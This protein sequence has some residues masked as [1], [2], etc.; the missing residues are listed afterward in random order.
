MAQS[1]RIA[2]ATRPS[3]VFTAELQTIVHCL[4]ALLSSSTPSH[5]HLIMSDSLASLSPIS[6]GFSLHLLVTRMHIPRI[7]DPQQ[8][9]H[10]E[11][12]S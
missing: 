3:L 8:Y 5:N 10:M 11:P 1:L 6:D 2:I 7:L 9:F 4:K 12:Q